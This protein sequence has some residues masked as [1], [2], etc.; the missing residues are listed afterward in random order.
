MS[1]FRKTTLLSV[2]LLAIQAFAS[3]PGRTLSNSLPPG[4]W[5]MD[6]KRWTS[7][8]ADWQVKDLIGPPASETDSVAPTAVHGIFLGDS[9]DRNMLND[10]CLKEEPQAQPHGHTVETFK[11]CWH[12]NLTLSWQA[13]VGIHPTGTA[14]L[15]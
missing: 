14:R 4:H 6:V 12:R 2:A 5:N 8:A 1:W 9:N 7:T 13:L 10:F 11:T 15:R 3:Q